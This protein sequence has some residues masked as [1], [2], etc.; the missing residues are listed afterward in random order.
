MYSSPRLMPLSSLTA[1]ALLL[2]TVALAAE[3]QATSAASHAAPVRVVDG[4][5]LYPVGTPGLTKEERRA[6]NL[7]MA[8]QGIEGYRVAY[9]THSFPAPLPGDEK[10]SA[11]APNATL[12]LA[13]SGP[14]PV[15]HGDPAEGVKFGLVEAKVF[16]RGTPDWRI[17]D[18]HITGDENVVISATK[19]E[20]TMK[21]G[22]KPHTWVTDIHYFDELGRKTKWIEPVSNNAVQESWIK[23]GGYSNYMEGLVAEL[24]AANLPVPPALSMGMEVINNQNRKSGQRQR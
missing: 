24:K 1:F 19:Y 18:Y 13:G 7:Y 21:D 9:K 6:R 20:G 4:V 16:W 5:P 17:T 2:P 23:Q 10:L 14:M 15:Q 8:R 22:S 11:W 3:K 12:D